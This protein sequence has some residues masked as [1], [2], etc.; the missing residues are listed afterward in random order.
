MD[1]CAHILVYLLWISSQCILANSPSREE[2]ITMIRPRSGTSM[3]RKL[4][5]PFVQ[6]DVAS[7][8]ILVENKLITRLLIIDIFEDD[9]ANYFISK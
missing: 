4:K 1:L 6:C 3:T 5:T 8:N 2:A 9:L 7:Y